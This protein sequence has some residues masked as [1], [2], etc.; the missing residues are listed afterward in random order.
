MIDDGTNAGGYKPPLRVARIINDAPIIQR[1]HHFYYVMRLVGWAF[2][3]KS[4]SSPA[5]NR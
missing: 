1:G 4:A 3:V 5:I 2:S